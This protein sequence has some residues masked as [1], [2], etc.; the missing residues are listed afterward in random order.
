MLF[1]ESRSDLR[2]I[3]LCESAKYLMPSSPILFLYNFKDS[4]LPIVSESPKAFAA[5]AVNFL[6]EIVI[7]LTCLIERDLASDSAAA[8]LKVA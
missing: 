4:S 2:L 3:S 6:P 1:Q 7:R 5:T 8:S